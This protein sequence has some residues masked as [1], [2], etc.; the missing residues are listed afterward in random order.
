MNPRTTGILVLVAAALGAFVYFYEIQGGDA[1]R[2]AE[3]REKRLFAGVEQDD[4]EWIELAPA[5]VAAAKVERRDGRWQLVAPLDFPADTLAADNLAS[6]L[7]TLASDSTLEG[8]GPP[9]EYGL[10]ESARIVRFGVGETQ[11]ELRLGRDAPVGE[12]T[13]ASTGSGAVYT[14]ARYK[15]SSFD[16]SPDDLRDKRILEFDRAA[17]Q[18]IEATWPGGHVVVEREA[19]PSADGAA[20]AEAPA[21]ESWRIVEPIQARADSETIDT[22]LGELGALRAEGFVDAPP[23]DAEA[24]LAQPAFDIALNSPG[25]G[26]GAGPRVVRFAIGAEHAGELLLARGAHPSLYTIAKARLDTMPRDLDAWRWKQLASFDLT[27]A[28]A[29]DFFFQSPPGDP[30]VIHAERGETGWSSSPEA[31]APGTL[32][33]A[34]AELSRLR[35]AGI[36]SD[37]P[38]ESML[39]KQGLAPPNA[40]IT[41]FGARPEGDTAGEGESPAPLPVLAEVQLGDVEGSEWI[42]ARAAGDPTLYRLAYPVAERVPVSLDAF[43]NRFRAEETEGAAPPAEEPAPT[44]EAGAD[45]PPPGDESP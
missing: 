33:T 40:V 12:G 10:G 9:D 20:Q 6:T 41:V 21:P 17:I 22:L 1:R 36:E 34:L 23:S 25:E 29:A 45:F 31:F 30:V 18:R 15:A 19:A 28:H 37:A 14:V 11:H 8:P 4:I 5:G 43:R 44:P 7:A 42:A 26:E 39:R 27:D 24:G 13:Y 3:E 38:D 32:D 35:A 16:K 2:E